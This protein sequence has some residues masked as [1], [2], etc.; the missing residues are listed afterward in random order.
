[1][2][3]RWAVATTGALVLAFLTLGT[4][5]SVRVGWF[6]PEAEAVAGACDANAKPANLNFILKDMNNKDVKL[7]DFKGKVIV[8][9]FW[10]TWCAPCKVEIPWFVALQNAYGKRGLQIIGVSVDDTLE[11]LKPF[12]ERYQ[13]NYPI[14]QGLG[15]DDVQD[16][17]GPIWGIP[18]TVVIGRDGRICKTHIG[19]STKEAFEQEIKSLL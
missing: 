16:A 2:Q 8:L 7:A 9:D 12:A 17:F 14:L 19:A 13:M 1:M 18:T 4:P 6:A 3:I 10:A 5:L 15:R 11:Q